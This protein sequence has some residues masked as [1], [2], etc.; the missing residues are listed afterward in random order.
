MA[1]GFTLPEAVAVVVVVAA[2]AGVVLLRGAE[3][4][5]SGSQAESLSNLR[6]YASANASY[7]ADYQDRFFGFSW[8]QTAPVN[9]QYDDLRARA[10]I[11]PLEACAAQAT[12]ILRRRTGDDAFPLPQSWIPNV[13][14]S[15][16]VLADYLE[17]A[18]LLPFAVS[19][20]DRPLRSWAENVEGFR[21]GQ[22][23]PQP[24]PTDPSNARYPYGSSYEMP[25]AVFSPDALTATT[26]VVTDGSAHNIFQ[27][28]PPSSGPMLMGGRRVTEVQFP[29]NKVFL[30]D[31]AQ[32]Q[33]AKAAVYFM[34]DHARVPVLM[35]D[36]AAGTRVTGHA[37]AG[38]NPSSPASAF[39]V[40][41]NYQPMGWEPPVVGGTVV[42]ARYRFTRWGLRGRDFDGQEV[43]GP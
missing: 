31:T 10:A 33:G 20:G 19:P 1:R 4:R 13:R 18:A 17:T 5:S 16:L 43:T 37:N 14:F 34:Y 36:G 26:G 8:R 28:I 2:A 41:T 38:F 23:P 24:S 22:F 35:M 27:T 11:G 25:P 40:Q 29:A 6:Q 21:E 3:G 15:H 7:G 30:Y 12:D 9:T 42:R 32:W 39:G